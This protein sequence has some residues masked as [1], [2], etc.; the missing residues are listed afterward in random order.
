MRGKH[1][2]PWINAETRIWIYRIALAVVGIF[3]GFTSWDAIT[4]EQWMRLVEAVLG[5]GV[6]GGL[7]VA[8]THVTPDPIE[9]LGLTSAEI[10]E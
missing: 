8:N 7:G 2:K 6:M 9:S 3:V 1:A 5:L 4:E 10:T